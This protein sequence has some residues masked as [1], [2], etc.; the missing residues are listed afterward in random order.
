MGKYPF[1]L[2]AVFTDPIHHLLGNVAAVVLGEVPYSDSSMQRLAA[3]LNQPATSFLWPDQK[4]N[5]YHVR[6]F[7]P[8]AE[9]DL[10]GHGSLAAI[11][12]LAQQTGKEEAFTLVYRN[13]QISGHR[14]TD[15]ICSITLAA[16]PVL[17]TEPV[18]DLLPKALGV[19]VLSVLRTANKSIVL[20]EKQL[21]VKRMEPDFALLRLLPTFGYAVTAPGEE[22]DF[23]SRTLVPHV[24]QLED[25][26]T[27]SSH[28]ALA[29]FWAQRLNKNQ[30]VAHQ[31]ST[32]G[33][34][35]TCEI[36]GTQVTLRGESTLIASGQ[37][38]QLPDLPQQDY[39][40]LS[41]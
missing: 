3:D 31:L 13:G 10:C 7:A 29:P 24:R 37:L 15:G 39:E 17:Q 20:V 28:A 36:S 26:A 41:G 16:I 34:K 2:I 38:L 25:P 27:G 22:V 5:H 1:S 19:P 18:P 11:A 35:F 33:G 8:D 14:N 21:D 23:V 30:L 32:R 9:I 6:W 40:T 4:E 12:Y